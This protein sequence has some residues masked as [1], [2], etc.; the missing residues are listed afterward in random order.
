M[1]ANNPKFMALLEEMRKTHESKNADYAKADNPYSNFE[2]TAE[3]AG[4]S[5]DTVFR[6]LMGVKLMR[7]RELQGSKMPNNES[8]QDSRKDLAVYAALYASYFFNK[9]IKIS[10][11]LAEAIHQGGMLQ[12]VAAQGWGTGKDRY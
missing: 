10:A 8:I 3:L 11:P 12:G 2:G 5:I 7:L 4:V 9:D 6:V 1:M